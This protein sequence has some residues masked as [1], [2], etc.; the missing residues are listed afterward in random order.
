MYSRLHGY[1]DFLGFDLSIDME[2]AAISKRILKGLS[3]PSWITPQRHLL[4]AQTPKKLFKAMRDNAMNDKQDG[5]TNGRLFQRLT[6]N[7][8]FECSQ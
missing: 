5:F 6:K 7:T 4:N 1:F 3:K 8:Y 2:L